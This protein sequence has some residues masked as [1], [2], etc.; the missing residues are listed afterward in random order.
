MPRIPICLPNPAMPSSLKQRAQTPGFMRTVDSPEA[1]QPPS[2]DVP[3][4]D[5]TPLPARDSSYAYHAYPV[6]SPRCASLSPTRALKARRVRLYDDERVLE[7]TKAS[8]E[9]LRRSDFYWVRRGAVALGVAIVVLS[10]FLA[11]VGSFSS[12]GSSST[13]T[14]INNSITINTGIAIA[15]GAPAAA[16]N[17]AGYLSAHPAAAILQISPGL[18]FLPRLPRMANMGA[19][20]DAQDS[21]DSQAAVEMHVAG[22]NILHARASSLADFSLDQAAQAAALFE[23]DLDDASGVLELTAGYH[24]DGVQR[25]QAALSTATLTLTPTLTALAKLPLHRLQP[26]V[27]AGAALAKKALRQTFDLELQAAVSVP[28]RLARAGDIVRGLV[29]SLTLT[30]TLTLAS[31]LRAAF[32]LAQEQCLYIQAYVTGTGREGAVGKVEAAMASAHLFAHRT[33]SARIHLSAAAETAYAMFE[34]EIGAVAGVLG[35][36]VEQIPHMDGL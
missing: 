5:V 1:S 6:D 34:V 24:Q 29:D 25:A 7:M 8:L 9:A 17:F 19:V 10:A 16:D 13:T 11:G 32:A 4:A 18:A 27:S 30:L 23:A 2:P 20:L 33:S 35:A 22:M 26:A 15:S 28:G 31:L 12:S 3:T 14:I 21:I 36:I